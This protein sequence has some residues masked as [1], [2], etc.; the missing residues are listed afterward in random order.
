MVKLVTETH[1]PILTYVCITDSPTWRGETEVKVQLKEQVS[2]K[3]DVCV[4]PSPTTYRWKY[5]G[6]ILTETGRT[7]LI[8]KVQERDLGNYSC[9]VLDPTTQSHKVF[10]IAV[11]GKC[12]VHGL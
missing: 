7:Y 12:N 2:L 4:Y 11:K 6:Q 5:N 9:E 1:Q 10:Y 3:C 8:E